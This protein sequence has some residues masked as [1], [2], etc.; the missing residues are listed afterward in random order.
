MALQ[1]REAFK[2]LTIKATE[3]G[4][5]GA[6]TIT[7]EIYDDAT[8][9]VKLANKHKQVVKLDDMT[10]T[11]QTP[12]GPRTVGDF[13]SGINADIANDNLRLSDD[14]IAEKNEVDRLNDKLS[15]QEIKASKLGAELAA[16][17]AK[18]KH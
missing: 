3:N 15:A 16:E 13:V 11:Y 14:L 12:L 5:V 8:N 17:K 4:M 10:K 9:E 2:E 6:L 18:G 1:E 7:I